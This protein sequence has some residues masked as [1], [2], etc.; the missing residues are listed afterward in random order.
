MEDAVIPVSN[1][2]LCF[3]CGMNV[4]ICDIEVVF[5]CLHGNDF[6]VHDQSCNKETCNRGSCNEVVL[7]VNRRY[8]G[9]RCCVSWIMN[10]GKCE[11]S[12]RARAL[13]LGHDGDWKFARGKFGRRTERGQ[14]KR[15]MVR[16]R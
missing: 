15:V 2:T 13:D 12:P 14:N 3:E 6:G 4:S 1:E 5:L 9:K 16:E 10:T 8:F 11:L 7:L